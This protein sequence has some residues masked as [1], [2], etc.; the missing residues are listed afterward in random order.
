M[1]LT[2]LLVLAA[3]PDPRTLTAVK[4]LNG[5]AD[6]DKTLR[7]D[8]PLAV[9]FDAATDATFARLCKHPHVGAITVTDATKLTDKGLG[10]LRELPALQ[11]LVLQASVVNDKTLA[12]I[13]RM[14]SLKLLYLGNSKLTD[15]GLAKLKDLDDITHLD[16]FETAVTNS[17]LAALG[18]LANLE[19]LNLSGT[20]VTDVTALKACKK[21]TTLKLTRTDVT[22]K[23]VTDLEAAL[24]KLIVR[25]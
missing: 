5:T 7:A 6:V 18:E 17:G 4:S 15:A 20:K 13:G 1:L 10:D 11:K 8:A 9:K 22:A 25:K 16:L 12:E 21:L 24:P 14:R 23:S 3:D 2:L 19:D